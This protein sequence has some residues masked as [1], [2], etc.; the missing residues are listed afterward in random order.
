MSTM[1]V[2]VDDSVEKRF[3][4]QVREHLGS[5]KGVLGRAITEAL[6]LW[7]EARVQEEVAQDIR[8]KMESGYAMGKLKYSSRDELHARA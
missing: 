4:K 5:G 8:A 3:R 1:T 6:R 2:S 7:I